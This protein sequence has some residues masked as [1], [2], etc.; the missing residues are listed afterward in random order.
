MERYNPFPAEA[1]EKSDP[2]IFL[3]LR[4]GLKIKHDEKSKHQK[5][6]RKREREKWMR[7]CRLE[8][9]R[10]GRNHIRQL[11]CQQKFTK[12]AVDESKWRCG[13]YEDEN[14]GENKKEE[15]RKRKM[16]GVEENVGDHRNRR[17]RRH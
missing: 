5:R 3:V 8:R 9:E 12:T 4:E 10:N 13:I 6:E 11:H 16:V 2:L 7:R 1:R 15:R 17:E 14:E